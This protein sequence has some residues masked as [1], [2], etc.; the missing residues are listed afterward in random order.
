MEE[1][2][3]R[4]LIESILKG[5]WLIAGITAICLI[6]GFVGTK[7]FTPYEEQAQIIMALNY[8]GIEKG[9][10][11]DNTEFDINLITAPTVLEKAL[12]KA[13]ISGIT[14]TDIKK[15]IEVT[16][17]IPEAVTKKIEAMRN[18]GEDYI[19]FPNEFII[20]FKIAKDSGISCAQG[21][22]LLEK[23]VNSYEEYFQELYYERNMLPNAVGSLDYEAYDY[24]EVS[25]VMEYQID[26]IN[27]YLN[28]KLSEAQGFRSKKTGYSFFDLKESVNIIKTVDINRMKSLISAY[29]LTKD[30][31]KLIINYENRIKQ[32]ELEKAKKESESRTAREMMDSF[33][34]EQNMLMLPGMTDS[35]MQLDFGNSY[36]DELVKR[37]TDAGVMANNI[38]HD[39]DY[40]LSEI[41]KIK[42]DA[43]PE[44][45]KNKAVQD[46]LSLI[47]SIREKLEY[48]IDTINETAIEYYDFRLGT[49]VMTLSPAETISVSNTLLN[50][51]IS[52]ALG[53]M[54]GI[55]TV[56]FKEYWKNSEREKNAVYQANV[57]SVN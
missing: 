34:R 1:I 5:K 33:K 23:I 47:D 42:N 31:E 55:F 45:M 41:E 3:L 16:P 24:P 32:L 56:L 53:I 14:M 19:F 40:Y 12:A 49:A 39:I 18:K 50:L 30:K 57:Q 35:G 37:S 20:T 29:N 28:K 15:N 9:L 6:A 26:I 54:L 2:S 10:N 17:I 22:Q 36:Y 11:P 7:V 52:M 21:R 27:E 46:V 44:D 8:P 4:D 48:S 38:Q 13:G 25:L 51:A 43:I